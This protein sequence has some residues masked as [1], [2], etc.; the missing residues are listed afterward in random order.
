MSRSTARLGA[1]LLTVALVG[2]AVPASAHVS[3]TTPDGT[4]GSSGKLVLRVPTESED[5]S[6]DRITVS[7]PKDTPF[8]TVRAR[9]KPGWTV[10]LGRT[11]LDKPVK[12]GDFTLSE[13]VSSITWTA[14]GDGVPPDQFDEFEFTAGPLPST[15]TVSFPTQQRYD[16]GTVVD[17][18]QAAKGDDEPEHPAPTLTLAAGGGE[19]HHGAAEDEAGDEVEASS[20]DTDTLARLIGVA[21]VLVGAGAVVV[22]LRQNRRRA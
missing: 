3:V 20:D 12:A 16:D 1:A 6:T 13:V 14:T 19:G 22:G 11:K 8:A 7:L 5:A 15:K 4:Q 2:I 18:D 9:S 10:E 21:G 17:W